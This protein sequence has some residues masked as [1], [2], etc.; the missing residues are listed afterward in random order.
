MSTLFLIFNH[1]FT[2]AQE[3]VGRSSPDDR[4]TGGGLQL[5]AGWIPVFSGMTKM[6]F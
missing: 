6:G 3:A 1:Q 4:V 5:W 2:A